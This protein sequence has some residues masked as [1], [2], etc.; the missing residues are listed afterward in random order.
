MLDALKVVAFRARLMIE[1]CPLATTGM[2]AVNRG[3][4]DIQQYM[5]TQ[6]AYRQ[7]SIA[8][9][10]SP[11]DCVVG[12]PLGPLAA[13]KDDLKIN[14]KYKAAMLSNPM[15]Y[16]TEAMDTILAELT[17]VA[18]S[19]K[20]SP[21]HIPVICNVLGRIVAQ[22]EASFTAYFPAR[23]CR[24]PVLFDQGI[25][26]VLSG[27]LGKDA[28][29][30]TWVEIGPHP[31]IIP[32]VKS[33][34]SG[35]HHSFIV[36][37]R[38]ST[39][40]WDTLSEAQ[41]QIYRSNILVNWPNT[42][43]E[44]PKPK[45]ITLPSYQFD[46]TDFLVEYAREPAKDATAPPPSSTGYEFLTRQT[47][48]SST[49]ASEETVFETPIE[50]LAQYITGHM[51]CGFALCPASVYHE[52]ALA[53][54]EVSERRET[55]LEINK[56][57][58]HLN[59]LSKISYVNPLIHVEGIPRVIR[60]AIKS[61]DRTHGDTKSFVVSSYELSRPDDITQHCEGLV[62]RQP[63]A[64]EESRLA[65][66][67]AQLRRPISLF[68]SME[69]A[70]VFRTRAMYEK[71]FTRVVTYSK[72]YQAVQSISISADGT[73]ALATVVM[74][75]VEPPTEG[76]FAVN[77]VFMDV[78]LHVA[79]FVANLAADHE[80]AFIC[81]EVKSTR[82]IMSQSDMHNPMKIYCS[83]T[84]VTDGI[85]GNGY[86]IGSNDELLAVFKGMHFTRVRLRAVEASFKHVSGGAQ[87]QRKAT[88]ATMTKEGVDGT[89]QSVAGSTLSM[90]DG[91]AHTAKPPSTIDTKAVIAEVCGAVGTSISSGSQLEGLGIDSLMILELGSR[92][93]AAT[94]ASITSN[95]LTACVTVADIEALV[96]SKTMEISHPQADPSPSGPG[97]EEKHED[98][99]P[100]T[101]SSS[102]LSV[103]AEIC[104]VDVSTITSETELESLGI[105][106]LMIFELEDRLQ[107]IS[108][109][110]VDGSA[111][112]SCRTVKD[113]EGL[114][115]QDKQP[116]EVEVTKPTDEATRPS[117]KAS[118]STSSEGSQVFSD[119]TPQSSDPPTRNASTSPL[120]GSGPS[121]IPKTSAKLSSLEE[122]LSLI[123]PAREGS[124]DQPLVLIHDGS[125]LSIPYRCL[126]DLNRPLWGISNP[127]TFSTDAWAD[128]DAMARAYAA[129]IEANI[130]GPVILGGKSVRPN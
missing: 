49:S 75:A 102:I 62:K 3:A 130:K 17:G 89:H 82:V 16:H 22:G 109:G 68:E 113:V 86:A 10:N 104:G 65:M 124:S 14:H 114:I 91:S 98:V 8:C 29:Q 9:C 93:Q 36:S 64:S 66:V 32:M 34:A 25:Q 58:T 37:M 105:D 121:Q 125:G 126:H 123:Q 23:H 43:A 106:S 116:M 52:M 107:K 100:S 111:L 87:H 24:Q 5:S 59:M 47:D 20:W 4:N 42:F 81:K 108:S 70:E 71:L 78:I 72:L 55:A 103:I 11:N 120:P 127:K 99:L 39:P 41:S 46:Y 80:D 74:P 122:S 1:Q 77:P 69:N 119:S 92:I 63:R 13:L 45:C 57:S 53:A 50:N 40:P 30:I 101:S 96:S 6:P 28:Q 128:L 79:G 94:D 33:Q 60:T 118:T 97:F 35:K 61:L 88:G 19:V 21:P 110:N 18:S 76:K 56:A 54:A 38:K 44:S 15:A 31:S 7:L 83:N 12:G 115:A 73:E 85:V 48:T 129:N 117:L 112:A 90:A 26:D 27:N 2:L 95:E 51:V 84:N 67:R